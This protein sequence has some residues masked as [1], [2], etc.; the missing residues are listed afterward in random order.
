MPLPVQVY[1]EQL[2]RTSLSYSA[3]MPSNI[4]NV[5]AA[6][7]YIYLLQHNTS[8]FQSVIVRQQ[9]SQ[10]GIFHDYAPFAA[11][12]KL[13]RLVNYSSVALAAVQ[14]GTNGTWLMSVQLSMTLVRGSE[15]WGFW[16]V[17][18]KAASDSERAHIMSSLRDRDLAFLDPN[19]CSKFAFSALLHA[20]FHLPNRPPR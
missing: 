1:V 6:N 4:T 14:S 10:L 5:T 17:R 11:T 2:S 16:A 12:P 19:P 20:G 8:V 3:Q 18:C 9:L 15:L 7:A 13:N